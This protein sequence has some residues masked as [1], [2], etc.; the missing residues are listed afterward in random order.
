MNFLAI[1]VQI[2]FL[3]N[4]DFLL[5][6][7][8]KLLDDLWSANVIVY[9]DDFDV[10]LLV[11]PGISPCTQF[12]MVLVQ[13][14][15]RRNAL[16]SDGMDRTLIR[17]CDGIILI[18][19]FSV[20]RIIE[21]NLTK[22][23]VCCLFAAIILDQVTVICKQVML[24]EARPSHLLMF[25]LINNNLNSSIRLKHQIPSLKRRPITLKITKI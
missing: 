4:E 6:S 22:L 17:R 2:Y 1:L 8:S 14:Y 7:E 21:D 3:L 18:F 15:V 13:F 20:A 10:D 25:L 19:P 9:V 5:C 16:G 12:V 24:V 11:P 23:K